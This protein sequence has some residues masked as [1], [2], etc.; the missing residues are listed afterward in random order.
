MNLDPNIPIL[1]RSDV[2]TPTGAGI[3]F[4]FYDKDNN[5]ELTGKDENCDFRVLAVDPVVVDNMPITAYTAQVL[6]DAGCALKKGLI[7]GD[8]YDALVS[9]LNVYNNVMFDITTGSYVTSITATPVLF[10]SLAL[11]HVLCNGDSTGTAVATITGGTAPY[12]ESW[13]GGA[14]DPAALAAGSHSLLVTDAAGNTLYRTF[15]ISE[16][17]AITAVLS[18]TPDSG[19][20]DGTATVVVSGGVAPY[21]YL[22]DDGGAQTTATATGLAAGDYNVQVT[23][24]N[25]C[26]ENFGPITVA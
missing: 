19:A 12:T 8:Q 4:L 14:G 26:V 16:P 18:S 25:G 5:N 21:T 17:P 6:D 1:H 13:D 7:N 22:W 23:D 9:N 3:Y 15:I 2:P 24:A 10:V 20:T 11:T